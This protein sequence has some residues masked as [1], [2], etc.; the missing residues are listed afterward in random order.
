MT[1]CET[2]TARHSVRQFLD[3]NVK[4]K[5]IVAIL[6]AARHSPSGSNTQPWQ[7]AVVTGDTKQRVTEAMVDAF[8]EGE[9]PNPVYQYYPDPMPS[10]YYDRVKACGI[11]LYQSLNISRDDKAGRRAQWAAN[12]RSFDA[13]VML[14]FWMEGV[15]QTGSYMDMGMFMQSTMLAA[16]DFGLATCP[17]AALAQYP[18]ILKKQLGLPS[19]AIILS[20]MALGYEDTE[21]DVNQ[22]RTAREELNNFTRYY[23]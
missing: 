3:K 14:I 9:S 16:L 18:D 7:V 17:Q 6:D 13:P 23:D 19:D 20:G 12:Y 11:A 21:A 15:M 1:I 22:V 2:I 5:D 10:P 4:Q 8:E